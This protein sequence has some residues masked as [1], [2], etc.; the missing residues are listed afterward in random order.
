MPYADATKQREAT[1][2]WRKANPDKV[3]KY[4]KT[5]LIR[6]M[7]NEQRIPRASS[8]KRHGLTEEEV[9]KIVTAVMRNESCST[10]RDNVEA[11]SQ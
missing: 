3:R 4:R 2:A 5:S 9:M 6:Q 11:C 1:E 10:S 7:L 8:V